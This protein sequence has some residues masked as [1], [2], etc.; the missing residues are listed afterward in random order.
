MKRKTRS[1]RNNPMTTISMCNDISHLG[2]GTHG[3]NK[4]TKVTII[5]DE[6]RSNTIKGDLFLIVGV[7][8]KNGTLVDTSHLNLRLMSSGKIP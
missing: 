3:A 2:W 6:Q 7:A 8:G 4:I 5:T 1:Y